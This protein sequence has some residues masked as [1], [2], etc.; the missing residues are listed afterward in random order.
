MRIVVVTLVAVGSIV[1]PVGVRAAGRAHAQAEITTDPCTLVATAEVEAVVGKL[2]GSP[3]S[4]QNGRAR[5]CDYEAANGTDYL[6]VW[7]YPSSD[8]DRFRKD[9]LNP[10]TVTGI[11]ED[12]FV[13]HNTRFEIVQLLAKKGRA[14]LQVM[15]TDTTGAEEKVKAIARKAIARF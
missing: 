4:S 11:G 10:T 13:A 15:L 1:H 8:L 7:L 9:A 14:L 3:R 2:K 12:A 6:S 5:V